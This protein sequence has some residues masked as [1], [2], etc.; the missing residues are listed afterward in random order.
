MTYLSE[1]FLETLEANK[2][3]EHPSVAKAVEICNAEYL[4]RKDQQL[5]EYE[6][7]DF[8]DVFLDFFDDFTNSRL[9]IVLDCVPMVSEMK[10]SRYPLFPS[11]K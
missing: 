1:L 9:A 3:F 5:G 10:R 2:S 8:L 4:L 7:R 6:L 11:V